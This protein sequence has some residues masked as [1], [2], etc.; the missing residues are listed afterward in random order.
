VPVAVSELY[1]VSRVNSEKDFE[2]SL[3]KLLG[4]NIEEIFDLVVTYDAEI[5][6]Q[7]QVTVSIVSQA[8]AA[9]GGPVS[10]SSTALVGG[11]SGSLGQGVLVEWY[12]NPV[13][14]MVADSTI[15]VISQTL[16]VPNLLRLNMGNSPLTSMQHGSKSIVKKEVGA[17]SGEEERGRL[18][19]S[20]RKAS[21]RSNSREAVEAR[22]SSVAHSDAVK[23]M[24]SSSLD[25]RLALSPE[26]RELLGVGEDSKNIEMSSINTVFK[27]PSHKLK[28]ERIR[29]L[30]LK[31]NKNTA[32]TKKH[33]SAVKLNAEGNKLI[34]QDTT[35]TKEAFVFIL[36]RDSNSGA[37][38]SMDVVDQET[39]LHNAVVHCDDEAFRKVVCG[40]LQS[41]K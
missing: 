25:P 14:D 28:L 18:V 5:V 21:S 17:E 41:L 29:D 37:D 23:K 4:E 30:V 38:V 26:I 36:F 10:V 27:E 11:S 31:G 33:F 15:S 24:K 1:L 35:N 8:G 19:G 16:A 22:T 39:S 6:I 12:A 3:L 2:R 32:K 40:V 13:N 34:F 20:R 7:N 9:A